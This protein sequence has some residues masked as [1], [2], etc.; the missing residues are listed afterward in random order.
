MPERLLIA[1]VLTYLILAVAPWVLVVGVF[2]QIPLDLIDATLITLVTVGIFSSAF[3]AYLV[4]LLVNRR[5]NHFGREQAMF[6]HVLDLLRAKVNPGDVNGQ[7]RL[8]NNYR[9]YQWLSESSSERSA[10]MQALLVLIPYLG[11]FLLMFELLLLTDDWKEHEFREDYMVQEINGTMGMLGLYQLPPRLRLSP[12]RSRSSAVY[13]VISIFTLGLAELVWLYLS[14][15]DPY[16]HF[17]YHSH[18][19]FPL[20]GLLGP[21]KPPTGVLP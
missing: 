3:S 18:L 15:S 14:T 4:Y 13:L 11:W 1:P 2:G 19:E 21:P 7:W 17:E 16:E 9:C 10:V 6:G 12:V 5:N 8:A 20:A